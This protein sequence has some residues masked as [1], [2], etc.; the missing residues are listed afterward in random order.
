MRG[1]ATFLLG[2]AI[3]YVLGTRAG[4]QRYEQLKSR[5]MRMWGNPRVQGTVTGL[6][7]KASETAKAGASSAASTAR[8]AASS[9]ASKMSSKM[10]ATVGAARERVRGHKEETMMPP[11]YPTV[12]LTGTS[13][14]IG[15]NG[16]PS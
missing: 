15:T 2:G 5:A 1:K 12:D 11:S 9:A 8:H 10:G 14:P 13:M 3:G 4:R 16:I 7:S 6:E